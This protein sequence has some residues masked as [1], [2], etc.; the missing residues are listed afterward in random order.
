MG[1]GEDPVSHKIPR[2][3]TGDEGTPGA[4]MY[5]VLCQIRPAELESQPSGQGCLEGTLYHSQKSQ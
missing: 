4:E 3:F 1:W 2:G 5:E